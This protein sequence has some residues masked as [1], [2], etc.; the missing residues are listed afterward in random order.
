[1]FSG[2]PFH[3]SL[4]AAILCTGVA[5]AGVLTLSGTSLSG[6]G[7]LSDGTYQRGYEARFKSQL[8]AQSMIAEGWA[9]LKLGLLGELAAGAVAGRGGWLFTAEEFTAPEEAPDFRREL[10]TT[11]A[12]LARA[13]ILLI[14]LIIPDKARI[15]T[16]RLPRPRSPAFQSRYGT[17]LQTLS[18][19]GLPAIDLRPALKQNGFLR[20]DTH[21][22]PEGA[23]RVAAL[24]ASALAGTP[25]ERPGF[26]TRSTGSVPYSGDLL[27]FAGSE[28]FPAFRRPLPEQIT[29]Y[30]TTGG[31]TGLFG[32]AAPELVLAGTSFSA[33]RDFHFGGF[34][35]SATGAD[36]VN[37]AEEGRGPFKPMHH[38]LDLLA[39]DEAGRPAA[40]IWEI[41]ERYLPTG[42][43]L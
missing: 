30:Q 2:K 11:R 39:A 24:A 1:M 21:W 32:G 42:D 13:D 12:A 31:A 36:L 16:A 35:Q 34:L 4:Q 14:P 41:P 20:T 22:T 38:F 27:P 25:M 43:Q 28:K 18:D 23:Q 26:E 33:R 7:R 40:V 15:E 10:Q 8:P 29:T 3:N 37:Y 6:Q 17:A 5:C 9:A 19:A